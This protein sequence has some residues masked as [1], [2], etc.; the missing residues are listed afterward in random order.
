MSRNLSSSITVLESGALQAG[1]ARKVL[2]NTY[3]LLG[4]TIAFS[5]AVAGT[6]M[7]MGWPAP[8]LILSL[9]GTLGLFYLTHKLANRASGLAAVFAL[10][11]FMGYML[12]PILNQVLALPHG[13]A[14]VTNALGSTAVAFLALSAIAWTSKRDFSFMGSYLMVGMLVALA[15]GLGAMFFEV[16]ALSLAVSGLVVLLMCGMILFETSRIVQGGETNY[17]LATVSLYSS[18]YNLF[19]SLLQ[20]FGVMGSDD[21]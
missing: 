12:G 3:A 16:P 17:I 11:G 21:Q 9:I 18:L 19:L 1:S 15:L 4:M 6:S 13:A 14:V 20:L 10:T 2:R 5:A 7:A 8:G